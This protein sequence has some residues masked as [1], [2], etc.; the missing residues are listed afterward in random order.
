MNFTICDRVNRLVASQWRR[1]SGGLVA[2]AIAT[3]LTISMTGSSLANAQV[4]GAAYGEGPGATGV[5]PG[6][7]AST[8]R[9]PGSP[10]PGLVEARQLPRTGDGSALT[11]LDQVVPMAAVGGIALLGAV[12]MVFVQRQR[13][14][15]ER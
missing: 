3:A 2:I 4:P 9:E 6:V 7:A 1:R 8:P 12:A 15:S 11:E 14:A 13:K 5:A 10:N